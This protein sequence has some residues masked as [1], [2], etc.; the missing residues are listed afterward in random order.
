MTKKEKTLEMQKQFI[1]MAWRGVIEDL[2]INARE[3]GPRTSKYYKSLANFLDRTL[4]D[5]LKNLPEYIEV[6]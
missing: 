5:T 3:A 4:E 1:I 2:E 6:D